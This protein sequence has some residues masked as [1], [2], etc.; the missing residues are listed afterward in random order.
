MAGA[1]TDAQHHGVKLRNIGAGRAR[2]HTD[3]VPLKSG[4]FLY[5]PRVGLIGP[6]F[7]VKEGA[8][9]YPAHI[10]VSD[11]NAVAA[12]QF[13]QLPGKLNGLQDILLS[14]IAA[15]PVFRKQGRTVG[16]HSIQPGVAIYA[17]LAQIHIGDLC[18]DAVK[19]FPCPAV[20]RHVYAVGFQQRLI[21]EHD[22]GNALVGQGILAA[23]GLP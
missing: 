6:I 3:T 9:G 4:V 5:P 16:I 8:E 13:P 2:G 19:I 12:I 17:V 11:G 10:K 14:Q 22:G 15:S 20:V 21:Y 23:F 18:A 1:G 7:R